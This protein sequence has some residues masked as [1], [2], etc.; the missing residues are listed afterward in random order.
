MESVRDLEEILAEVLKIISVRHFSRTFFKMS[1][2]PRSLGQL[3]ASTISWLIVSGVYAK[4]VHRNM[5]R[6]MRAA[7]I[8]LVFHW[9]FQLWWILSA[10]REII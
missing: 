7:Y 9:E 2:K 10:C 5:N 3:E 6:N 4:R 1:R 8:D